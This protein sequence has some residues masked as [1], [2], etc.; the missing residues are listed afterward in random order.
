MKIS[1]E[2]KD[3][4]SEQILSILFH[5]FPRPQY[6]VNL[7]RELARDEEFIKSI[8]LELKEKQLVTEINKNSE[9]DIYLRRKRWMLSPQAYDAYKKTQ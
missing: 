1:K 2:K 5:N 8:L 6:T 4:I 3:K 9:G 7:A